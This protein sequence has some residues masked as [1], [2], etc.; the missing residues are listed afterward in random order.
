MARGNSSL[1]TFGHA[2][3]P[4]PIFNM[5]L[6]LDNDFTAVR[7]D[8]T[9]HFSGLPVREGFVPLEGLGQSTIASWLDDAE[10]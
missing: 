7:S 8:F 4:R 1:V 10:N 6:P 3:M 2:K 9:D 5:I